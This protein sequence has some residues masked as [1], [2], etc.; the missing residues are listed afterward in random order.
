MLDSAIQQYLRQI[1]GGRQTR[2]PKVREPYGLL[3]KC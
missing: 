1:S 2:P 3:A